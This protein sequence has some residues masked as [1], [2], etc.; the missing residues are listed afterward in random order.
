MGI[1]LVIGILLMPYIV[2]AII[3]GVISTKVIKSKMFKIL[4]ITGVL[5]CAFIILELIVY[6]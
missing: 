3:I 6:K 4:I 5:F 1:I 2:S